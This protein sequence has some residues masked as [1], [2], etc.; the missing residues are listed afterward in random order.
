[1]S[2]AILLA[3]ATLLASASAEAAT[4][5]FLID[6][7]SVT[8]PVGG[9]NVVGG[10]LTDTARR[11]ASCASPQFGGTGSLSRAGATAVNTGS[12]TGAF[13]RGISI[14]LCT[15]L[16]PFR[17]AVGANVDDS[18]NFEIINDAGERS[19]GALRYSLGVGQFND[20]LAAFGP[21]DSIG[22][23]FEVITS[24]DNP[25]NVTAIL[26][27]VNLGTLPIGAGFSGDFEFQLPVDTVPD[28]TLDLIFLGDAGYDIA[29]DGLGLRVTRDNVPAPAPLG[30]FGLGLIALAAR[31]RS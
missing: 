20:E 13:T 28:G 11:A 30:L 5:T 10:Y 22:L 25:V 29:I 17:A 2:R 7:F 31:R 24:D 3:A 12:P 14:N 9:S 8:Q 26:G 23:A 18:S 27:G 15:G 21:Y 16:R 1:M 6:D 19:V 4:A